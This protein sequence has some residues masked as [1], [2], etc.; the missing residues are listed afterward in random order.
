MISIFG[1]TLTLDPSAFHYID[2][3]H[4]DE[5]LVLTFKR[6]VQSFSGE[7]WGFA[8]KRPSINPSMYHPPPSLLSLFSSIAGMRFSFFS[9]NNFSLCPSPFS[10]IFHW[11]IQI[12]LNFWI[13]NILIS[14]GFFS[15]TLQRH[16]HLA[17]KQKY[18]LA[19]LSF[20]YYLVSSLFLLNNLPFFIH[21]N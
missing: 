10:A 8:F 6:A 19:L 14:L 17:T 9:F 16:C 12:S 13:S 3:F 21:Y 2:H 15:Q 11:V 1:G 5:Q 4:V 20:I 7:N 18:L